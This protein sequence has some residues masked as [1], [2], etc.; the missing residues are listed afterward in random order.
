MR[1][2]RSVSAYL[3]AQAHAGAQ[4]LMIFDTWGG[5]L[6]PASFREFSL[7][8]MAQVVDALKAD[9]V[10]RELPVILF[11]KGSNGQLEALAERLAA[12]PRVPRM[13]ADKRRSRAA[14]ERARP[15]ASY[16]A[17]ELARMADNF[18]GPDASYHEAR[19]RFV[20]KLP[21]TDSV[22]RKPNLAAA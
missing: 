9:P 10:S 22:L 11:S 6:G 12:N 7:R 2:A 4:A 14:D 13:L 17:Q 3:I 20:H 5:M 16:R 15:L 1:I 21:G 18:F 19:H 8:Y